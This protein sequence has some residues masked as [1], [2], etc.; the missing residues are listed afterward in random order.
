MQSRGCA[1]L[2]S[3]I[4]FGDAQLKLIR[5]MKDNHFEMTGEIYLSACCVFDVNSTGHV[6]LCSMLLV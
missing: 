2:S 1:S 3:S 6:S 5:A 4:L